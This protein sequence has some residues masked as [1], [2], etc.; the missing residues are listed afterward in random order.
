MNLGASIM[1]S[2]VAVTGLF[3]IGC[4]ISLSMGTH[5]YHS[6]YGP[7]RCGYQQQ[8]GVALPICIGAVVCGAMFGD[9]L[10]MIS[11]TTHCGCPYPG[12]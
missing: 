8:D 2:S 9:N 3:L 10:S 1:P 7:Y 5:G 11:D 12:M 4:F 6:C